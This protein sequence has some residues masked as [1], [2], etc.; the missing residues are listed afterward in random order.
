MFDSMELDEAVADIFDSGVKVDTLALLY[1]ANKNIK[2]RVKTPSGLG[3]EQKFSKLVLQGD[4]WGPIMASNQVDTFGKQLI[5]KEPSFI[6]KYKGNVPVGVLG[7]IDDLAGVSEGAIKA[8]HLNAFYKC[9]NSRK[10]F[11]LDQIN[12]IH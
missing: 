9:E 2:V 6:Y 7:M 8:K 10:N 11:S 3:V 12:T 5:E 4:T 1:N